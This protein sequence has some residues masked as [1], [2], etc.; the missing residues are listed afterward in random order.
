MFRISLLKNLK[1]IRRTKIKIKVDK[2]ITMGS[3]NVKFSLLLCY[4]YLK[5]DF[6]QNNIKKLLYICPHEEDYY[7]AIVRNYECF[8]C[9][10][11]LFTG[12]LHEGDCNYA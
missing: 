2:L 7:L 5:S 11:A 3:E 12:G 1:L 8:V 6:N 4:F 10:S 9:S